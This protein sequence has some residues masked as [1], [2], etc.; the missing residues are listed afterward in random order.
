M[1]LR[2]IYEL[3]KVYYNSLYHSTKKEKATGKAREPKRC[4]HHRILAL[5]VKVAK[6]QKSKSRRVARELQSR[7]SRESRKVEK[8][9]VPKVGKIKKRKRVEKS[10]LFFIKLFTPQSR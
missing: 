1:L 10:A 8:V 7:K 4:S 6:L 3:L 2:A 5:F 9:D